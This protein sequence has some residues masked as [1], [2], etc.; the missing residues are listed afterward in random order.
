ME[1]HPIP[2]QIT[3]FE[4]KLIGFL[5]LKQ[6][7]YVLVFA[8]F[9][10]I[11]YGLIS[12]PFLNYLMGASVGSI[13]LAFAFVPINDRP[14]DVWIKNLIKRLTSPT[15]YYYHKDNQ[16]IA[17]LLDNYL[18][19]NPKLATIHIDSK[20]KLKSYLASK[21]VETGALN[22]Q[23]QQINQ[24]LSSPLSF[25]LPKNKTS[26]T[27]NPQQKM[28]NFQNISNNQPTQ[29]PNPS[30]FFSGLIKNHQGVPLG[31]ILVYIKKPQDEKPVRIL[32]TNIH[33]V[34]ATFKPFPNG[35]YLLE[36]KDPKQKYFFDTIKI[37][38]E[39]QN[40]PLNIVSKELI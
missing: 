26:S 35:E 2:R 11:V 34:F 9:G 21:N 13:G 24:L 18:S 16:P 29:K 31:E 22:Q 32:K 3:T 38:V 20:E 25:L 28:N 17:I 5:T 19:T 4:F 40:Q 39:N 10:F 1:Q 14:L 15:Q 27:S 37:R 7:I 8:V 30:P 36:V 33:G 12:I 6:F 23:K